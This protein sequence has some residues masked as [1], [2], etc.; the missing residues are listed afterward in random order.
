MLLQAFFLC[1]LVEWVEALENRDLLVR[2]PVYDQSNMKGFDNN[3]M[4]C[5]HAPLS[6]ESDE[7]VDT[8]YENGQQQLLGYELWAKYVNYEKKG[9]VIGSEVWG[10]ELVVI[11]DFTDGSAVAE[12]TDKCLAGEFGRMH[13]MFAPYSSGLTVVA[14]EKTVSHITNNCAFIIVCSG[15]VSQLYV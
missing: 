10:I 14:L 5:V 15:P 11:D 12:N 4:V 8:F 1:L 2:R 7:E 13:W 3:F 6:H 9:I